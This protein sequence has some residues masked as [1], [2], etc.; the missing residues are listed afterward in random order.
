MVVPNLYDGCI[1]KGCLKTSSLDS[2]PTVPT[3]IMLVTMHQFS[4]QAGHIG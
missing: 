2:A 3:Y 1:F 4:S